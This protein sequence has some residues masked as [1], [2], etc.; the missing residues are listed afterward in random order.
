M[1]T[2]A[3]RDVAMVVEGRFG[4][5]KRRMTSCPIQAMPRISWMKKRTLF[6]RISFGRV[7][8]WMRKAEAPPTIRREEP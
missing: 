4:T 2:L 3:G 1:Q 7:R 6:L 5:S 8:S